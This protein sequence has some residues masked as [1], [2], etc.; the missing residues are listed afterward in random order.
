MN[1]Q[2][3]KLLPYITGFFIC[4][5]I[6][7]NILATKM[8]A[9][10]PFV[11]DG[12]TLLFP[13][14]YIVSDILSEV[15]GFKQTWKITLFGFL[16]LIFVNMNIFLISVLPPEHTWTLQNEFNAILLQIPRITVGSMCGYLVGNYSNALFLSVVKV[17]LAGKFLFIR[18]IGS[19]LVGELLDSLLFVFIAFFGLYDLSVLLLMAFSN[20]AFKTVIEIIFTPLT[21]KV[22]TWVKHKEQLDTYDYQESYNPFLL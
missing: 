19:T 21:Y 16:I 17:K 10:G 13:F 4:T 15:Y 12:G 18:T 1:T 5:L 7:S 14:S 9:I 2:E 6:I 11:F 8:I 20:Y 3:K 22:I